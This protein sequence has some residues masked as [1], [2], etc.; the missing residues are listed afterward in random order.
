MYYIYTKCIC[1]QNNFINSLLVKS[2]FERFISV[3]YQ[4][5]IIK[6]YIFLFI[7]LLV[8]DILK[9]TLIFFNTY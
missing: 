7:K 6:Y 8:F 3:F 1:N 9:N 4:I 2:N 5:Q